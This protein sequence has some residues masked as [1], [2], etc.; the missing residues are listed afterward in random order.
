M[1]ARSAVYFCPRRPWSSRA[2]SRMGVRTAISWA[3]ELETGVVAMMHP[4]FDGAAPSPDQGRCRLR[5]YSA[6]R[7]V[8]WSAPRATSYLP[9]HSP[10]VTPLKTPLYFL[11]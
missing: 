7:L 11:H 8:G 9:L 5:V 1:P 4:Q 3:R 2:I 10:C 6:G